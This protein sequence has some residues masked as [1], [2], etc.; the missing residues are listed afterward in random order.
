MARW[1][2]KA[3]P[4]GQEGSGVHQGEVLEGSRGSGG[5]GKPF[6]RARRV[7][8]SHPEGCEWSGRVGS[9]SPRAE[10]DQKALCK[11]QKGS[12]SPPGG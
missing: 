12:G 10:R 2:W 7:R 9:P 5:V 1:G 4:E 8:E 11:G 3:L 6:W